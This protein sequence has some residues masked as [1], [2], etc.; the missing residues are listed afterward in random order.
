MYF[1]CSRMEVETLDTHGI[2]TN[3]KMKL[4]PVG[5]YVKYF[6]YN[7][8]ACVLYI[9]LFATLNIY[10]FYWL[11]RFYLYTQNKINIFSEYYSPNE[12]KYHL[13]TIRVNDFH[14]TFSHRERE[15]EREGEKAWQ[16][17][18]FDSF[19]FILHIFTLERDVFCIYLWCEPIHIM[20]SVIYCV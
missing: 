4:N 3:H 10:S 15:R 18:P 9:S 17:F 13:T 8:C 12:T 2:N 11:F 5:N 1:V 7:L 20:Q 16:T 6:I 14:I 19:R